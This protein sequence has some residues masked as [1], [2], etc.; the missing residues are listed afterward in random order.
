M[1][2]LRWEFGTK[3]Q[4][5]DWLCPATA[6]YD[7]TVKGAGAADAG[8]ARGGSGAVISALI[9]IEQ[10]DALVVFVGEAGGVYVDAWGCCSAGGGG[11]FA[12]RRRQFEGGKLEVLVAAGGGGGAADSV[13]IS[14][15]DGSH[16]SVT[17]G[18]GDGA[19]QDAGAGGRGGGAGSGRES[20]TCFATGG[21]GS[22]SAFAGSQVM[23]QVAGWGGQFPGGGSGIEGYGLGAAKGPQRDGSLGGHPVRGARGVARGGFGGGG[24]ANV[25][26]EEVVLLVKGLETGLLCSGGEPCL[27]NLQVE[28]K[29]PPP[30]LSQNDGGCSGRR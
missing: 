13:T 4:A 27:K 23:L 21:L 14:G 3:R 7:V 26:R 16:A 22:L 17:E 30:V 9:P 5:Q 1:L 19:G 8:S 2:G 11:T 18:G 29:K 10:G 25:H 20:V 6:L 24:A 12:F 15:C 28:P